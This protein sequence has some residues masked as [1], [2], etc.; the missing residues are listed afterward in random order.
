MKTKNLYNTYKGDFTKEETDLLDSF[1][2]WTF[3]KVADSWS[4]TGYKIYAKHESWNDSQRTYA[5]S[6]Y[7]MYM[8]LH[9]DR[10]ASR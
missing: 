3:W 5:N 4:S 10:M 8:S 2:G 9:I 7:D 6:A 1:R